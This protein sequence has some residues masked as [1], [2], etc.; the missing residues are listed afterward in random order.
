M[1]RPQKFV[2]D[3]VLEEAMQIFWQNGYRGT[4][5]ENLDQVT[6]LNRGSL[7]NAFGGKRALYLMALEHYG[8]RQFGAAIELIDHSL[9]TV[10]A[11]RDLFDNVINQMKSGEIKR[12][13]FVCNSAIECA[14]SDQQVAKIIRKYLNRMT[15]SFASSLGKMQEQEGYSDLSEIER[16]SEHLTASYMGFNVLSKANVPVKSLKQIRDSAMMMISGT[17]LSSTP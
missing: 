14:P 11:V 4:T 13:C 3:T 2:H 5:M 10:E 16:L 17:A 1:A 9:S 15:A 8:D 7:Y 12:G 6:G